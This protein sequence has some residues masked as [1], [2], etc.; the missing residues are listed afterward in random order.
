VELIVTNLE[1]IPDDLEPGVYCCRLESMTWQEMKVRFVPGTRHQPGDCL[2]Q[3]AREEPAREP[4]DG[5]VPCPDCGGRGCAADMTACASCL[6]TGELP[7]LAA[8]EGD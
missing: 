5:H 7:V 2:I 6:G 8:R 3:L 4:D 1:E